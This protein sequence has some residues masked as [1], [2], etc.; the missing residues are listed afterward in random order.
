[1]KVIS[2]AKN[3]KL[4]NFQ[5]STKQTV[6]PKKFFPKE[7]YLNGSWL[8]PE[9]AQ[10]SVFDRGFMLGDGIYEVCPFYNGKAF[11]LK[12]HLQRL[13]Y[14]LDQINLEF[15]AF[16]LEEV[17]YEA[18]ERAKLSTEDCA[19]Y[20]QVTRGVAPRTHHYPE[21]STPTVLLYVYPV[22]LEGFEEKSWKVSVTK[23]LRWHRCDIKSIS[24]LANI[25]ANEE[26][27]STGFDENLLIR[28]GWFTEGS[29]T[30]IFFVKYGMVYTHPEGP[31]ILSGITRQVII[32]LCEKLG[33]KVKEE[34]VH[35]DELVEVE[36]TFLTG[37]T[38]QITKVD[39]IFY[40]GN[41]VFKA[42]NDEI[43]RKLQEVFV[44]ETRG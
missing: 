30:T 29:H 35:L 40:E 10:V 3:I 8:K 4:N 24:L 1:M 32:D 16:S 38:T 36:E 41:E 23:D 39:S 15:D 6:K 22:K 17:I 42:K 5:Y 13:Q 14:C 28:N 31:D 7:V 9:K 27:I 43:T 18:I 37:T 2:T 34:K 25:R 19:V 12:E 33:I 26:G 20:M 21:K 44:R 11:K